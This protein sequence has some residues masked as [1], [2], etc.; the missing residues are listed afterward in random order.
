VFAASQGKG[1]HGGQAQRGSSPVIHEPDC[2]TARTAPSARLPNPLRM[3]VAPHPPGAGLRRRH[4]PDSPQPHVLVGSGPV[5]DA[6]TLGAGRVPASRRN[7]PAR[8]RVVHSSAVR[9]GSTRWYCSPRADVAPDPHCQCPSTLERCWP[10]DVARYQWP[11]SWGTRISRADM[12]RSLDVRLDP[13]PC[14]G[15][16]SAAG[17]SLVTTR[18]HR[19]THRRLPPT[20]WCRRHV[21]TDPLAASEKLTLSRHPGLTEVGEGAGARRGGLGGDP[22]AASE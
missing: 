2:R 18:P 11:T 21:N 6:V 1:R 20:H 19:P 8:W 17:A 9:G 16:R 14:E 4:V 7:G 12:D 15:F 13:G 3:T 10:S 5:P 22:S